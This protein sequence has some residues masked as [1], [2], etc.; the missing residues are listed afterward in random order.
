MWIDTVT[1]SKELD[2]EKSHP[3][4]VEAGRMYGFWKSKRRSE[5]KKRMVSESL[6][7]KPRG[8]CYRHILVGLEGGPR[9]RWAQRIIKVGLRIGP[10]PGILRPGL[11]M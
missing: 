3:V 6:L 1:V 8:M 4:E 9:T 7:P 10:C 2:A 5:E 11:A